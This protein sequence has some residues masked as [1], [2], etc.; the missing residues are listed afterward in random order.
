MTLHCSWFIIQLPDKYKIRILFYG[1]WFGVSAQILHEKG[2][3]WW[4]KPCVFCTEHAARLSFRKVYFFY[5]FW[6]D[7]PLAY[8]YDLVRFAC[9][10]SSWGREN[11][12]SWSTFDGGKL[13]KIIIQTLVTAC[14][15]LMLICYDNIAC[16]SCI[17]AFQ[18][19]F[20]HS[21]LTPVLHSCILLYCVERSC[22]VL[23]Q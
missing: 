23:W 10:G 6:M 8:W 2:W 16:V 18:P 12:K 15:D 3:C 21:S 4:Q 20:H 11:T 14:M 7:V 13:R 9:T 19:S 1:R 22:S 17:H 5:T